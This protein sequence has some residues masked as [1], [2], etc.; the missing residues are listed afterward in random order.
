MQEP[1][2]APQDRNFTSIITRVDLKEIE[3]ERDLQEEK[4]RRKKGAETK[5]GI[6]T[7]VEKETEM[8]RREREIG[9]ERV[10]LVAQREGKR[11]ME[12]RMGG[13]QEGTRAKAGMQIR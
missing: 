6:E 5:T 13:A 7:V 2:R 10:V 12:R 9:K 1:A 4:A 11:E 3:K 8:T